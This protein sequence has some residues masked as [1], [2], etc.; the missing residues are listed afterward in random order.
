LLFKSYTRGE[1]ELETQFH[2]T[3]KMSTVRDG[4]DL[5]TEVGNFRNANSSVTSGF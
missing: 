4:E 3:P 2:T 1:L 5:N